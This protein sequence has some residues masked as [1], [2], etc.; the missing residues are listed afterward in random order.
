MRGRVLRAAVW[1]WTVA[2]AAG[3]AVFEGLDSLGA[4]PPVVEALPA[5]A[6]LP[7]VSPFACGLAAVWATRL[8]VPA[9]LAAAAAAVWAR[10][11]A[12]RVIGMWHGVNPPPEYGVVLVLAFGV[13][14]MVSALA[15]GAIAALA[16]GAV[17]PLIGRWLG[18]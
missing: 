11:G 13:P 3:V 16:R 5:A 17:R 15:G 7:A 4:S 9:A 10:I 1:R 8:P 12:D 14:W 2:V 6:S 18:S